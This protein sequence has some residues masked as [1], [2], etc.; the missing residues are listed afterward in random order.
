MI[1]LIVWDLDG[2]LWQDSLSETGSTGPIN[3]EVVEFIIRTERSGIIHSV[4]SKNDFITAQKQLIELGIWEYFIFPI[5][6]YSPKGP[7]VKTIIENCQLRE[8]NVLFVD[9]NTINTN[10]V[11]YYCPKIKTS[12]DTEFIKTFDYPDQSSRTGFYKILETK[13]KDQ[14]NINFLK[15]SNINIA[16][17]KQDYLIMFYDRIHELVNRSNQLN[18][19]KSRFTDMSDSITPYVW[20]DNRINHAVFVWD[21]YGY[22]GLVGYF[23][24]KK[25]VHNVIEH[26]TFSC[27]IL[28][29]GIENFCGQ[30]IRNQGYILPEN[31][32][33]MEGDYSYIKLNNFTDVKTWILEQ[34]KLMTP[35]NNPVA[36]IYAGCMSY[37]LWALSP[38]YQNITP[39]EFGTICSDENI[40]GLV[41]DPPLL[42][43]SLMNEISGIV[44]SGLTVD[45][46]TFLWEKFLETCG[47][48]NKKILLLTLSVPD[49]IDEREIKNHKLY[50]FWEEKKIDK[51]SILTPDYQKIHF[52]K[53]EQREL[54]VKIA[55]WV[56]K[57]SSGC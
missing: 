32:P 48:L 10:E 4:C 1:K 43:I 15:D 42:I 38:M 37:S 18:F 52:S 12:N 13:R 57:N 16:I 27:R 45:E 7:A 9:D 22:Y 36:K 19:T 53:K 41:N 44:N 23:S 47:E 34:E 8:E 2:V 49:L 30:F 56:E 28:N 31:M 20:I 6:E 46:I 39:A 54:S 51:I 24:T 11:S 40:S 3:K 35:S 50:K 25:D 17:L 29:M 55:E 14:D 26:F 5:I 33:D 21:K